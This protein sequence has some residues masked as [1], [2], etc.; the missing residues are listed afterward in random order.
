MYGVRGMWGWGWPG[1]GNC[2]DVL[3]DNNSAWVCHSEQHAPPRAM[4]RTPPLE[5]VHVECILLPPITPSACV[6]RRSCTS[7]LQCLTQVKGGDGA[8]GVGV[9]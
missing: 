4:Q 9:P 3:H 1:G 5:G 2:V 7:Q 8:S 6:T